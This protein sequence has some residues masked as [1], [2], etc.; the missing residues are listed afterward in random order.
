MNLILSPLSPPLGL[1]TF[2]QTKP[3][4]DAIVRRRK[5]LVSAPVQWLNVA[6]IMA[7]C[8]A[9]NIEVLVFEKSCCMSAISDLAVCPAPLACVPEEF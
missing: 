3:Q 8:F 5:C 7:R 9:A 6:T 4:R 1:A 2:E